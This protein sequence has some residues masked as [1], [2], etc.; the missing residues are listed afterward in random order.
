MNKRQASSYFEALNTACVLR[1]QRDVMPPDQIW[2]GP[3]AFFRI[4]TEDSDFPS[5]CEMKDEPAFKPLQGNPACFRVRVSRCLGVPLDL[6]S[7]I[8]ES[9]VLPKGRQATVM[10]DVECGMTLVPMQGN[11]ASHELIWGTL[12]YFLLLP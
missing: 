10:Y 2:L 12:K 5:P 1:C 6:D 7:Y 4:S 9:F 11:Q 3:R 8:R